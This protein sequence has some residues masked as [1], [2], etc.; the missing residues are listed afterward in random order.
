M[1]DHGSNV[2]S[3]N[4]HRAKHNSSILLNWRCRRRRTAAALVAT[5]LTMSTTNL[6]NVMPTTPATHYPDSPSSIAS[7]R[8]RSSRPGLG[9]NKRSPLH[10]HHHSHQHHAHRKT[11][12][13]SARVAHSHP[14]RHH[15]TSGTHSHRHRCGGA[16]HHL[17]VHVH[18]YS[19]IPPHIHTHIRHPARRHPSLIK[20]FLVRAP[21]TPPS[22][23]LLSKTPIFAAPQRPWTPATLSADDDASFFRSESGDHSC[24]PT[25]GM[26]ASVNPKQAQRSSLR[27]AVRSLLSNITRR[28][29][30]EDIDKEK[31]DESPLM[32]GLATGAPLRPHRS[33]GAESFTA[34]SGR[35]MLEPSRSTSPP[36]RS[37]MMAVEGDDDSPVRPHLLLRPRTRRLPDRLVS[38]FSD[39]SEDSDESD[40]GHSMFSLS[41][42]VAKQSFHPLLRGRKWSSAP[43]LVR[44]PLRVLSPPPERRG[45]SLDL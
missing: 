26:G 5:Q 20:P 7:R 31:E 34:T 35:V 12:A 41:K 14:H 23:P 4:A 33:P 13:F 27:H 43:S 16:P 1:Y 25:S 28:R 36:I 30:R 29:Q 22:S 40:D 32:T 19:P 44:R 9:I 45:K 39:S 3:H 2:A 42:Q 8:S 38:R 6:T 18:D 10:H 24:P 11:S 17:S 15:N 21:R 37:S